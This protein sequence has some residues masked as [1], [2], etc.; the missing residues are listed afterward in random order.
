MLAG[1]LATLDYSI[2][3]T[4]ALRLTLS[5]VTHLMSLPFAGRVLRG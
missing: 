4:T 1:L 3:T 5:L 2:S